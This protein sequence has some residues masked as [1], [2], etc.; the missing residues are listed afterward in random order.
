MIKVLNVIEEGRGGGPLFQT[1]RMAKQLKGTVDMKVIAPTIAS[2]FHQDL[3]QSGIHSFP[4]D[5]HPLTKDPNGLRKYI[6]NLVELPLILL[7]LFG[8]KQ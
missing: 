1:A 8:S 7:R 5:I 4:I 2:S 6:F 3:E